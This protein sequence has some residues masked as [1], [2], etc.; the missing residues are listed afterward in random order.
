MIIIVLS[1]INFSKWEFINASK[2]MIEYNTM[3]EKCR[4]KNL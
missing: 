2:F 3:F 4:F 1:S